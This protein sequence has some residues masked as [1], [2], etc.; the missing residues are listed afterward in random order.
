MVSVVLVNADLH[1]LV[2]QQHFDF[3][4][5][6]TGEGFQS[7]RPAQVLRFVGGYGRAEPEARRHAGGSPDG[8][9]VAVRVLVYRIE[10]EQV[11][12]FSASQVEGADEAFFGDVIV[13]L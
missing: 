12:V 1:R 4:A 9:D 13:C 8:I 5:H 7:F 6:G 11:V 10:K 3:H 2:S